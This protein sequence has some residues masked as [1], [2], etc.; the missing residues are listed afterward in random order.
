[1]N[2]AL[3]VSELKEFLESRG[4]AHDQGGLGTFDLDS[5]APKGFDSAVVPV[6]CL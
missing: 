4:I 5:G 3:N 2:Y 1:V 6:L